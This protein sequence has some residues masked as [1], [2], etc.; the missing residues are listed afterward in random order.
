[1][2]ESNVSK[3]ACAATCAIPAPM[4]PAPKTPILSDCSAI[5]LSYNSSRVSGPGFGFSP[6][7]PRHETRDLSFLFPRK[8]RRAFFQKRAHALVVVGTPPGNFLQMGFVFQVRFN[9]G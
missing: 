4:V 6:Q 8:H 3:P 1:M 2:S 9:I 7:D 5:C